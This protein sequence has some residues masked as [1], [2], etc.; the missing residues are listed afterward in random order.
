MLRQQ[1][2]AKIHWGAGQQEVSD[3][4]REEHGIEGA[5]AGQLLADAY[6]ARRRAIRQRALWMLAFSSLGIALVTG[7]VFV[8]FFSG[9]VFGGVHAEIANAAVVGVGAV[10]VTAFF[11]SL[12][13]L[14]T[15]DAEGSVD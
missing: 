4:L 3:W 7:F 12:A 15:G 10:S 5:E 2:I 8:R 14:F 6:R 9:A 11:R 13:R 1:V